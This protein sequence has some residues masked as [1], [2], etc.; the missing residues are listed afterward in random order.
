M[1]Y[2]KFSYVRHK[3]PKH[4][5]KIFL[6]VT[7]IMLAGLFY[8]AIHSILAGWK[9]LHPVKKEV[10]AFHS[11][12]LPSHRN[13][14]FYDIDYKRNLNGWFFDFPESR[15]V[16]VMAHDYGLNRLQFGEDTVGLIKGLQ[17]GGYDVFLFDFGNSGNSQGNTTTFGYLETR[18]LMGAIRYLKAG[19]GPVDKLALMG[20]GTGAAA[21]ICAA[22]GNSTVDAVIADSPY[23][24]LKEYWHSSLHNYTGLPPLPFNYTISLANEKLFGIVRTSV[25]PK[26]AL[27]SISG[28]PL[29]LIHSTE[30]PVISVKNSRELASIHPKTE[31][32]EVNGTK[33]A[34]AYIENP[35]EYIKRVLN[36]LDRN[37]G[38]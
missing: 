22:G 19:E 9:V 33:H 7:L 32:W 12:I 6:V 21:S 25:S 35:E 1:S 30:D 16:I 27:S 3:Q 13:I 31:L 36:F 14:I 17:A 37:M 24:S 29:M 26:K 23:S 28:M 18:D 8:V 38:K 4:T 11:N 15:K 20:F 5:G 2:G 34:Q 10:T